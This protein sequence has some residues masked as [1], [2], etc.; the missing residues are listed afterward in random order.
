L[1]DKNYGNY[2]LS[3]FTPAELN[4]PAAPINRA[5]LGSAPPNPSVLINIVG[6]RGA[7]AVNNVHLPYIAAGTYGS[8]TVIATSGDTGDDINI[9]VGGTVRG[10]RGAYSGPNVSAA[11]AEDLKFLYNAV[12]FGSASNT[13]RRNARRTAAV[14]DALGAP[15]LTRFDFTLAGTPP[16]AIV[17]SITAPIVYQGVLFAT[18]AAPGGAGTLRAYDAQPFSDLDGDNNPDDGVPDL[19]FGAPYDEVWRSA[20]LS[21]TAAV[22]PSA[23]TA[24]TLANGVDAIYVTGADGTLYGFQAFP[25]QNGRLAPAATPVF[26]N[27]D[28]R[29]GGGYLPPTPGIPFS[30]PSPVVFEGRVHVALPDG[31]ILCADALTG[32]TLWISND[33][34]PATPLTPLGPPTVGFTRLTAPP[35]RAGG[36]NNS[37]SDLMLYLPAREGTG[38]SAGMG[39]NLPSGASCPSFW[40]AQRGDLG[41]SGVGGTAATCCTTPAPTRAAI[42]TFVA[43]A[44]AVHSAQRA[45]VRQRGGRHHVARKL[46]RQPRSSVFVG[47]FV[48]GPVAGTSVARVEVFDRSGATPPRRPPRTTRCLVA[49]DY[50]VV[51]ATGA[52]RPGLL[53]PDGTR[54]PQQPLRTSGTEFSGRTQHPCTH[55]RRPARVFGRGSR[56]QRWRHPRQQHLRPERAARR[57]QQ[58]GALPL[59]PVRPGGRGCRAGHSRARRNDLRPI[60]VHQRARVRPELAARGSGRAGPERDRGTRAGAAG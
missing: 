52:G 32:A 56:F 2:H 7:P 20:A 51:Y 22:L 30:A 5:T 58:Q 36:S 50:D 10:N 43:N 24:A 40:G 3:A 27:G 18:G 59:Q 29:V 1:G 19:G 8:G 42:N 49:V 26:T 46:Y 4:N 15:L 23:P 45:R 25:A 21:S 54:S 34:P 39:G 14:F 9:P 12:A 6:N 57:R 53:P 13:D 35:R 37:T 28:G 11:H 31:R 33:Q 60:P 38:M 55:A 44:P 41:S 47:R 16:D 17:D 48:P